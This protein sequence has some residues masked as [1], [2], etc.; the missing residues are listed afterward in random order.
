MTKR[1][2]NNKSFKITKQ[3]HKYGN[4]GKGSLTFKANIKILLF[5]LKVAKWPDGTRW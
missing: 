4:V 3:M 5:I 2:H 1:R